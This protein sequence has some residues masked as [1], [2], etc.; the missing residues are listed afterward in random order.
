MDAFEGLQGARILAEPPGTRS[1]Y[2]FVTMALDKEHASQRDQTMSALHVAG[3]LVRPIWN[4]M[5]TLPMYET[6][7]RM[8]LPVTEDLASRVINLPSS[9]H[10]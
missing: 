2:W 1:N 8:P 7:P 3:F 10:L 4:P 5:H 9:A 6:C